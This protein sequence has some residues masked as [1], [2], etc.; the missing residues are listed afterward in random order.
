MN[1]E[2]AVWLLEEIEPL[3][4]RVK[5]LEALP[6]KMAAH[7]QTPHGASSDSSGG[8]GHAHGGDPTCQD[9]AE[10]R[11]AWARQGIEAARDGLLAEIGAAAKWAGAGHEAEIV[12]Q[13]FEDYRAAGRPGPGT[14][15][16]ALVG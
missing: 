4:E 14:G 9:C 6:D 2:R 12:A 13:A 15:I 10:A 8:E 16:G 1:E 5:A 3:L 7:A 11:Q